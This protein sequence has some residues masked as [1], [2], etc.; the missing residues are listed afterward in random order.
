MCWHVNGDL[1]RRCGED[2]ACGTE[3]PAR[4]ESCANGSAKPL[5]MDKI[6]GMPNPAGLMTKHMA[7]DVLQRLK[8]QLNA[9]ADDHDLDDQVALNARCP[10]SVP[11]PH[12]EWRARPARSHPRVRLH[13]DGACTVCDAS[14]DAVGLKSTPRDCASELQLPIAARIACS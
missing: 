8:T 13:W 4:A 7:T 3:V 1:L 9:N 10:P 11:P 5:R 12:W 2:E 14:L 6:D